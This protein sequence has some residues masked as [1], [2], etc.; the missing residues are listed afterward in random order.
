MTGLARVWRKS[1]LRRVSWEERKWEGI[2]RNMCPFLASWICLTAMAEQLFNPCTCQN[3]IETAEPANNGKQMM[4]NM[5]TE[6]DLGSQH[7]H[8]TL[9]QK[10]NM[11]VNRYYPQI[12]QLSTRLKYYAISPSICRGSSLAQSPRNASEMQH[13]HHSRNAISLKC[14]D[15]R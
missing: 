1:R 14:R 10:T 3:Q 2:K 5:P 15:T 6:S 7:I 4:W 11:Q 8:D 12:S 9:G 13:I